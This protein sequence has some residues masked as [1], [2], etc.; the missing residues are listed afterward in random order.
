[1]LRHTKSYHLPMYVLRVGWHS[2][3]GPRPPGPG[4][5]FSGEVYV[6]WFV[7]NIA[8]EG[9]TGRDLGAHIKRSKEVPTRLTCGHHE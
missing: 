6:P 1:M 7:T 9:W 4:D 5:D 3:E 2:P 8:D